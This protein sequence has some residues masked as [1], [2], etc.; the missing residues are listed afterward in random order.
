M[1]PPGTPTGLAFDGEPGETSLSVKWDATPTATGY[2]ATIDG[3]DPQKVTEPKAT[4]TGLEVGTTYKV[5]VI[6]SNEGGDSQPASKDFTT[7]QGEL[8]KPVPVKVSAT[9]DSLVVS[10]PKV[11]GANEYTAVGTS[12]A[13]PGDKVGPVEELDTDTM[14]V[15]LSDL[16]ADTAY[17][18]TVVAKDKDG[19]HTDSEPGTVEVT[20]DKA[21]EA[22]A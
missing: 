21:E 13:D 22:G 1:T 18:V 10:W 14:K 8:E 15:T 5:E 12:D 2:T 20:T 4:F 7:A 3:K 6:A 11:K 17:T 19:K 16:K 9:A